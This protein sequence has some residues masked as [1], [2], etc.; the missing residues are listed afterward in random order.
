[1]RFVGFVLF[2]SWEEWEK[3]S[4][5]FT[6]I[7]ATD[8]FQVVRRPPLPSRNLPHHLREVSANQVVRSHAGGSFMLNLSYLSIKYTHVVNANFRI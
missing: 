4:S 3:F 1:V 8:F 6:A 5:S 7:F 2:I